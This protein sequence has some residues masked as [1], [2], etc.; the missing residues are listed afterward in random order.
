MR[1]T[2]RPR[3]TLRLLNKHFSRLTG[4]HLTVL[5]LAVAILLVEVLTGQGV[6]AFV[7]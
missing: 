4:L 2:T 5:K 3:Y 7:A 6:C 1:L